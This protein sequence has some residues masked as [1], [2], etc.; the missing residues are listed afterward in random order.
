MKYLNTLTEGKEGN[1]I[2]SFL[3]KASE[4]CNIHSCM[5]EKH[6]CLHDAIKLVKMTVELGD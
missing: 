5:V 6:Y 2:S 4:K 1:D 3:A